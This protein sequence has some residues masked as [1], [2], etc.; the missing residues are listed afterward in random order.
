VVKVDD[1][2]VGIGE[3]RAAGTWTVG[4]ALTGN[5]AGL[6]AAELA[7]L[8]DAERSGIRARATAEM[9][10]VG[11]DLVIDSVAELPQAVATL[12]SRLA[13]GERPSG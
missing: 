7:A 4:V 12:Q 11:A 2:P 1:T 10:A 6:S 8:S 3:G 5:I 13:A 9:Q